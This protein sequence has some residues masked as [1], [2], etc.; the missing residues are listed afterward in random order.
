LGSP[1]SLAPA[2]REPRARCL[3]P[4]LSELDPPSVILAETAD[5]LRGY[6]VTRPESAGSSIQQQPPTASVR[7]VPPVRI[8]RVTGLRPR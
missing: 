1:H 2:L 6:N 8:T 7:A 3:H 4:G 5:R